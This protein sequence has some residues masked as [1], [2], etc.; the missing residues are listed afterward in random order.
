MNKHFGS[1]TTED[2]LKWHFRRLKKGA[3]LQVD[4]VK[5]G[6]DP[7]G[8]NVDVNQKGELDGNKQGRGSS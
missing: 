4:A 2:G 7:K 3:K 5:K 8:V 1:D 6:I